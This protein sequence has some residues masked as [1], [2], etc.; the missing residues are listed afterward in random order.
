MRFE[1]WQFLFLFAL[2][3]LFHYFW[4][5]RNKPARVS[6]SLPIPESVGGKHPARFFCS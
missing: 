2:I 6:F 5:K 3:P 1:N 4:M